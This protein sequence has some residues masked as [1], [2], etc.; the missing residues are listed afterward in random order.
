MQIPAQRITGGFAYNPWLNILGFGCLLA[1]TIILVILL[2]QS[3]SDP[4]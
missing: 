4:T 3:R 1:I 2:F